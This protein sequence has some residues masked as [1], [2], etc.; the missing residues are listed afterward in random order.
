MSS[1]SPQSN[2]QPDLDES[3]NVTKAHGRVE[4]ETAATLRESRIAE[5][6]HEPVALWVIVAC[7][8]VL[9]VAGAVLGRAGNFF[10][11]GDL[12]R[13]N[14]V[15]DEIPGGAAKGPASKPALAAFSSRGKNIYASKCN[16]CHGADAKGD[17]AN[18]P[19]L[20]GSKFVIGDT[21]TF[22]MVVLNGI[23]GPT[24]TGKVYGAGVMPAQGAGMTAVELASL[25]T[26]VRNNFGNETGDV[27]SIDM[28]TKAFEISAAREKAGQSVTAQ[29]IAAKHMTMLPGEV[30]EPAT[31][32]NPS[33]L[34][35]AP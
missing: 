29:E 15:R 16:G 5:N 23:Q 12:T 17:G 10:S 9:L 2:P 18:Y 32:V 19:S 30:L 11:Y 13:P 4:L 34:T 8:I 3:I 20:V 26:F 21:Q 35:P 28:A 33:N 6:G 22:A 24:S 31:M 1:P 14:Y 7:G 27:V 25:M